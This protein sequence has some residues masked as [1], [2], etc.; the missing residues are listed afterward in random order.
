MG[1]FAAHDERMTEALP[2]RHGAR[3]SRALA[4]TA[5]LAGL[6]LASCAAPAQNDDD[7]VDEVSADLTQQELACEGYDTAAARRMAQAGGRRE[8][9]RS[10]KRCYRYV[11]QHLESAGY[12]VPGD[13]AS[14]GRYAGSA[15]QFT[16]WARQNPAALRRLG[17]KEV[18]LKL[19]EAP[20]Q[21]AII[22]W[23][24]GECG[25]SKSHGHIEVVSTADGSRACSDFCGRVKTSRRCGIPDVFIP[26][27]ADGQPAPECNTPP[28]QGESCVGLADGWY[29]SAR[30][31]YSAYECKNQQVALGY[32]CAT[33][34]KCVYSGQS[35]QATMQNG[36]PQCR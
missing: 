11:K 10:Q 9:M 18:K 20:P 25:Y 32:Q 31:D 2:R 8:G 12:S 1:A 13:V 27:R 16:T 3:A 26:V 22:V 28:P 6:A 29:C 14:G 15:Y 35:R 34:K 5:V 17:F 36:L 23:G 7:L 24:R 21:G 33:G 4:L 19:G 30:S